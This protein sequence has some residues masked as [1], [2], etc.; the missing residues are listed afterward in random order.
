MKIGK[1]GMEKILSSVSPSNTGR[2]IDK[3]ATPAEIRV[4]QLAQKLGTVRETAGK[5]QAKVEDIQGRISRGEYK[6]NPETIASKLLDLG[7]DDK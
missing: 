2:N 7:K 4:S 1:Y 5:E 3:T 6:T